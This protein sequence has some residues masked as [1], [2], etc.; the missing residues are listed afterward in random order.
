M[1][2][3]LYLLLDDLFESSETCIPFLVNTSSTFKTA[4]K[5]SVLAAVAGLAVFLLAF[6]VDVGQQEFQ[7]VSAQTATTSLTVLNTPPLFT[8][9]A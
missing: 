6:M 7:R 5:I 3:V 8:G 1:N 4:G 2:M 9:V